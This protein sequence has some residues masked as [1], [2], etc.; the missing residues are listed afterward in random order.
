MATVHTG[1]HTAYDVPTNVQA[2]V[3][4]RVRWGPVVAGLFAALS[5]LAVLA[6]LGVAIGL[7]SIDAND[8]ARAFGIGA[9]IWTLVSVLIAFFVG[10]LISAF[11]AATPAS[12]VTGDGHL[13][14]HNGLLQGAMVW[15]VA[16]PLSVYFIAGGI[17]SALSVAGRTA[18]TGA[19]AAS[20]AAGAMVQDQD[21]ELSRGGADVNSPTTVPSGLRDAAQ[22][23]QQ[24]VQQAVT[25]ERVE[26]A[27]DYAGG[28]AWGTLVSMIIGLGAASFG[29]L[30]GGRARTATVV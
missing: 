23:A 1:N 4:D 11:T 2:V 6:V 26:K 29:G 19:E 12:A 7:S 18:A 27:G 9:G 22:S 25:P 15:M 5:T 20:N 10:G 21:V 8:S 30:V 28:A 17:G 24:Q 3:R 14:K 16:I 13:R